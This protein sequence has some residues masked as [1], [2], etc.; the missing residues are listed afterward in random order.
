LARAIRR[1]G[2]LSTMLNDGWMLY[3]EY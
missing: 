3:R 2:G 1:A